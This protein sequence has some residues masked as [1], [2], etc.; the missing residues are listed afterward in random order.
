MGFVAV[1]ACSLLNYWLLLESYSLLNCGIWAVLSFGLAYYV[2]SPWALAK[3][4]VGAIAWSIESA[5]VG[6]GGLIFLSL[7]MCVAYL[8]HANTKDLDA[9]AKP[10]LYIGS[11]FTLFA[12]LVLTDDRG[13][14]LLSDYSDQNALYSIVALLVVSLFCSIRYWSKVYPEVIAC[15]VIA[16]CTFGLGFV[17]DTVLRSAL[18]HGLLLLTIF[19]FVSASTLRIRDNVITVMSSLFFTVAVAVLYVDDKFS[20]SDRSLFLLTG[21]FLM[22][23]IASG[24]EKFIRFGARWN[25]GRAENG[26]FAIRSL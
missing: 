10:Y 16:I 13:R 20:M 24:V 4:L 19:G 3:G 18:S 21:G 22:L 7:S 23:G 11:F 15:A 5:H 6:A 12:L 8:Y 1:L 25:D 17:A 26:I 14:I 2:R 9:M